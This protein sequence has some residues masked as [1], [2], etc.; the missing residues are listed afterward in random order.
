MKVS[1]Q[2]RKVY[3]NRDLKIDVEIINQQAVLEVDMPLFHS[4]LHK[5]ITTCFE[6]FKPLAHQFLDEMKDQSLNRYIFSVK[7]KSTVLVFEGMYPHSMS[8]PRFEIQPFNQHA[9]LDIELKKLFDAFV[10]DCDARLNHRLIE[11]IAVSGFG[12]EVVKSVTPIQ[13]AKG[14]AA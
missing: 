13:C 11:S 12:M 5:T 6:Y 7:T 2:Q 14:R 1:K 3:T 4:T 9:Q 10:K 8:L